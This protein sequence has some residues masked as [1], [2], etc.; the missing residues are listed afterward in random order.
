MA[1]RQHRVLA[2][3][4]YLL[5]ALV[6]AQ[7]APLIATSRI[8]SAEIDLPMARPFESVL[9]TQRLTELG[10]AGWAGE[11]APAEQA[12]QMRQHL[13]AEMIYSGA[14]GPWIGRPVGP[15]YGAGQPKTMSAL[16]RPTKIVMKVIA[17]A[18]AIAG[19]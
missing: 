16:S 19:A 18:M 15:P 5:A 17:G 13:Y 9:R 8:I 7:Q 4:F 14:G 3:G 10:Y 6:G 11:A 1:A 2:L 12:R